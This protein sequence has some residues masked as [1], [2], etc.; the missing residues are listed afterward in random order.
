MKYKP[1]SLLD[2]EGYV[3]EK[4][5]KTKIKKWYNEI[6]KLKDYFITR[7]SKS[8]T[9][10]YEKGVDEGKYKFIGSKK[11][12]VKIK[13]QQKQEEVMYGGILVDTEG[14]PV[15]DK[16]VKKL[17]KTL[18]KENPMETL[19]KEDTKQKNT[20]LGLVKMY[21]LLYGDELDLQKTGIK[22]VKRTGL[23]KNL[24]EKSK[25]KK[26]KGTDTKRTTEEEISIFSEIM[27]QAAK[28]E[29]ILA[30]KKF[31]IEMLKLL[32]PKI[33]DYLGGVSNNLNNGFKEIIITPLNGNLPKPPF[34]FEDYATLDG[35]I[36]L[37]LLEE[38]FK[39]LNIRFSVAKLT[40]KD[41][42]NTLEVLNF[43]FGAFTEKI[44][45][46]YDDNED[47]MMNIL[48]S[49]RPSVNDEKLIRDVKLDLFFNDKYKKQRINAIYEIYIQI[50]ELEEDL[51][52]NEITLDDEKIDDI[53][54]IV[55]MLSLLYAIALND[56][57]ILDVAAEDNFDEALEII[58]KKSKGKV[59][60]VGS[61]IDIEK[62][63]GL[64][65]MFEGL[66][67]DRDRSK[68]EKQKDSEL[69]ID[70]D[71]LGEMIETTQELIDGFMMSVVYDVEY[72]YLKTTSTMSEEDIERLSG[73][74]KSKQLKKSYPLPEHIKR[75]IEQDTKD[76]PEKTE[77]QQEEKK[78]K[79]Q[80]LTMQYYD[81]KYPQRITEAEKERRRK[82]FDSG[83]DISDKELE[84][85]R[86]TL[87]NKKS[88][89]YEITP[90]KNPIEPNRVFGEKEREQYAMTEEEAR[91]KE[92]RE[93][94]YYNTPIEW[95]EKT[96]EVTEK[97]RVQVE[98]TYKILATPNE[99][100]VN[101]TNMYNKTEYQINVLPRIQ[102]I[103]VKKH[104]GGEKSDF[105]SKTEIAEGAA[106]IDSSSFLDASGKLKVLLEETPLKI[107]LINVQRQSNSNNTPLYKNIRKV[108]LKLN[109]LDKKL[110]SAKDEVSVME[111][112]I[113]YLQL[114]T[115]QLP[116]EFE[117][118]KIN[119]I[120]ELLNKYPM[121]E[122]EYN[123]ST[124]KKMKLANSKAHDWLKQNLITSTK[125]KRKMLSL[126]TDDFN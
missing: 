77:K 115:N 63:N 57:I 111:I 26:N 31:N 101:A 55:R 79:K 18:E 89:T 90:R 22:S 20:T 112:G 66:D 33:E 43:D 98:T 12:M 114:L 23:I 125:K 56:D 45:S 38:I 40:D 5:H 81:G 49:G 70:E 30:K 92:R 4:K 96:E 21:A 121:T 82:E 41:V 83:E 75:K 34:K 68:Q 105:R 19:F 7:E 17:M 52:N 44:I 93:S 69:E 59:K 104:Y 61:D 71:D 120:E 118:P 28:G 60:S 32:A 108:E 46:A 100:L 97:E 67:L 124:K 50:D 53:N 122:E 29:F 91:Q 94:G 74:K 84:D 106:P 72:T 10:E 25:G 107:T 6:K 95:E 35:K 13:G 15:L 73:S 16:N 11:K 24:L 2:E 85:W 103:L 9:D 39:R 36:T 102:E 51:N 42:K 3:F 78:K 126:H 116:N 109:A 80:E 47:N 99:N 113:Q 110:D 119:G 8:Y 88:P 27:K 76:M 54:T 87:R 123:T 86:K 62:V 1:I 58:I 117:P 37:T 14:Y 48:E 64:K 65:E